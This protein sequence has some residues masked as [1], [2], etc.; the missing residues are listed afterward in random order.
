MYQS[1][2]ELID[3]ATETNKPVSELM[4]EQE[5]ETS[6][7]SREV[8]WAK[9]ERNLK[10]M[11]EAVKRGKSGEVVHSPTGLTGGEAVK[12]KHYAETHQPLSGKAMMGAVGDAIATNEV[13]AAI[14]IICATPTAGSSGTMPGV[15]MMLDHRLHLTHEQKVR[16]LFAGGAYGLIIANKACIAGTSGGCQAEVGSASGMAAAAAVETAGGTPEQCGH[17]LAI[18]LANL[19]GRSV[20]WSLGWWKCHVS[21]GTLSVL[22]TP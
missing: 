5:I 2:K 6:G 20:T 14:G 7:M 16:F 1:I 13:N 19:M 22:E 3:T 4:I 9:M 10:V 18:A 21:S 15:L 8:I 11:E 17:A 12:I